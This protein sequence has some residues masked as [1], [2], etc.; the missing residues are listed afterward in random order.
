MQLLRWRRNERGVRAVDKEP[1]TLVQTAPPP[2]RDT[3]RMKGRGVDVDH[4]PV[5]IESKPPPESRLRP[6]KLRGMV[7]PGGG[8]PW[9]EPRAEDGGVR[10]VR[11][12]KAGPGGRRS[13]LPGRVVDRAADR[14]RLIDWPEPGGRLPQEKRLRDRLR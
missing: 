8:V 12:L 3:L 11:E 2:R 5:V 14:G 7:L 4:P 1:S 10:L 13:V 9:R 6:V